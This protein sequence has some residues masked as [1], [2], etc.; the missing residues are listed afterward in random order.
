MAKTTSQVKAQVT[1]K[2]ITRDNWRAATRL[3]LGEGQDK[4]VAPNWYS[5][6]EAM[7][8]GF[9]SRAIYA[10]EEMVGYTMFGL[11]DET[12]SQWIARLMIAKDHQGKGYGRAAMQQLIQYFRDLPNC[13]EVFI[14]FEPENH[15]AQ[16]LYSSLGFE[17][18]GRLE[19]GELVYRLALD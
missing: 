7:F 5:I 8:D 4:F 1:L 17:D 9:N 6:L 10:D 15:P 19:Y 11:D 13:T 16:K 3:K 18:T 2:E 14:S 12:G